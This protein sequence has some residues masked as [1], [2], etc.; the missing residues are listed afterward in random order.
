MLSVGHNVYLVRLKHVGPDR[1]TMVF[2]TKSTALSLFNSCFAAR[3]PGVTVGC[4]KVEFTGT[5]VEEPNIHNLGA[6]NR[7]VGEFK[8]LLENA[9]PIGLFPGELFLNEL[10]KLADASYQRAPGFVFLVHLSAVKPVIYIPADL[11][12]DKR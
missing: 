8:R 1:V 5:P 7:G 11:G 3:V 12:S 4:G 6:G 9:Q 2:E 10:V